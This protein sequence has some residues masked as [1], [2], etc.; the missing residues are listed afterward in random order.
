[1]SKNMSLADFSEYE[2]TRY[3]IW[4][5]GPKLSNCWKNI[6][7]AGLFTITDIIYKTH[8]INLNKLSNYNVINLDNTKAER[9]L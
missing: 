6:R 8:K 4:E 2:H 9:S 1:M 7:Q 5:D 3:L